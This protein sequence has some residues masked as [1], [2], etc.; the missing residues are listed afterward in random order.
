MPAFTEDHAAFGPDQKSSWSTSEVT[1]DLW[2][3]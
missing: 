3:G 1:D 2:L